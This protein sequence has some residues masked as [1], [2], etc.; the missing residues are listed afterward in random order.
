MIATINSC[1]RYSLMP[2][3]ETLVAG[4]DRPRSLTDE[5]FWGHR[6]CLEQ[7]AVSKLD[8]STLFCRRMRAM[9]A[10]DRFVHRLPHHAPRSGSC[11]V[12]RLGASAWIAHFEA[13]ECVMLSGYDHFKR[14]VIFILANFACSHT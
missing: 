1:S 9:N 12:G 6:C 4:R 3:T 7:L 5:V 13:I 10:A 11:S 14:L 2:D 8:P